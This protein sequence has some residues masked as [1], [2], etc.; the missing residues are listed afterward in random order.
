MKN[1]Q[2]FINEDIAYHGSPYEFDEFSSHMMYEGEGCHGWGEGFYFSEDIDDAKSY[3]EKLEQEKGEGRLY[4]VRIPNKDKYLNIDVGFDE[5]S[6]YVQNC[7]MKMPKKYKMKLFQTEYEENKESI[8]NEIDQYDFNI[9]DPD[10]WE[11]VDYP[12]DN[13]LSSFGNYFNKYIEEY[14]F[15]NNDDAESKCSYF[16]SKLGIKGN[17][18]RGFGHLN[19]VVF[20]ENDIQILSRTKPRFKYRY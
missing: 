13:E 16:L 7:L 10:Y 4:K 8:D 9:G 3:A 14:L 11:L 15:D 17:I 20:N 2:Q 1:F 12:L 6:E 18:H 19:Y 5:Q